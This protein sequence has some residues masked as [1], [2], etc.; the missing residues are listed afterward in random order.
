LYRRQSHFFLK[1]YDA[2]YRR[3]I[4]ISRKEVTDHVLGKTVIDVGAGNGLL[5]SILKTKHNK[6]VTCVDVDQYS[7]TYHPLTIFDGINLPF[8]NQTFDTCLILFVLHHSSK[9]KELLTEACRVTRQRLIILEDDS[10][11][12]SKYISLLHQLSYNLAFK[13]NSRVS[14]LKPRVW[15]DMLQQNGFEIDSYSS[16][17]TLWSIVFPVKKVIIVASRRSS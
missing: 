13:S 1:L 6:S 12:F 15:T 2:I 17:W 5:A 11:L 7:K 9:Q 4:S 8:P 16:K 3:S 10:P 14:Y